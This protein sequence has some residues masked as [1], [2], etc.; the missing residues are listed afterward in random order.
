MRLFISIESKE[1]EDYFKGIQDN[2]PGTARLKPVKSFHLTLKFLGDVD[3]NKLEKIKDS[4]SRIKFQP[5]DTKL[6]KI[7]V[8]PSEKQ[9]RVVWIGL[10]EA[11]VIT[12]LQE[13]IDSALESLFKKEKGFL[14]HITLAR[15]KHIDPEKKKDFTESLK[16]IEVEPRR[17]KTECF[18]LMES[19]LTP[20][21]PVY[22][23]L[24]VYRTQN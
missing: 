20:E 9:I 18:R 22:K 12:K 13:D 24:A 5:I 1:L 4:L 3:E 16:K 2:L 10:S 14:S 6:D 11:E 8:F 21:G 23:E 7:G 19:N 17:F 15:V